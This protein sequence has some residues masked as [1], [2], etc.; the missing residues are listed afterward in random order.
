MN[1]KERFL[2]ALN[3]GEPDRVPMFDL[4]FNEESILNIGRHFTDDLP[5]PKAFI[6]C[7]PAETRKYYDVLIKFVRELDLDSISAVFTA[8]NGRIEGKPDHFK[9]DLGVVY[10]NSKHGDPFPVGGPIR[11]PDDLKGYRMPKIQPKYFEIF[12]YLREQAPERA[13]VFTV[14]GPFK[15]GWGLMGALEK[16]LLA[17]A[18]T[19]DFCLQLAR[20]TTDFVKSAIEMAIAE[21]ADVILLDGD[22]SFQQATM[23][24]P[25]HYRKF[26]KPFHQ[27]C[28]DLAHAKGL[29]IIKH[30]D[31][32]FW[33]VMDDLLEIGFDGLHPIQ[34]QCMDI[35]EVKAHVRGRACIVGNIDCANL[36]PFGTEEEVIASV[37]ETIRDIAPGGGYILSSSNS[38]HPACDPKNV[39]AMFRAVRQYGNY[40]IRLS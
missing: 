6:D 19:P 36:L 34:P 28:V 37:R 20:M 31:G 9:D 27:E 23:M 18:M 35:R 22:I 33:L 38:I 30:S 7:T 4:E 15:L 3:L 10:L 16:L 14:P 8:D 25:A 40:P 5:P 13:L 12:K 29:P 1:C 11:S 26:L 32:N 21:G 24:S 2:T 39:L 17:F